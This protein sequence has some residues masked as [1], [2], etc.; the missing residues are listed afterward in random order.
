MIHVTDNSDNE[1]L[2]LLQGLWWSL[3]LWRTPSL[4]IHSSQGEAAG[5]DR[6]THSKHTLHEGVC[7][8]S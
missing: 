6:G 1:L 2:L 4:D 8:F 5:A 7:K 3:Q